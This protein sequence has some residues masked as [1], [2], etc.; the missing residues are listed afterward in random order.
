MKIHFIRQARITSS[1]HQSQKIRLYSSLP[2]FFK[3][4]RLEDLEKIQG[5]AKLLGFFQR[6]GC[7]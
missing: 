1:T 6:W 5:N 4:Q 3:Q 7:S 2:F